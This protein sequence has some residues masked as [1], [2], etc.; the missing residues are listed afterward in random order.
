MR[1]VKGLTKESLKLLDRINKHSKYSQVRKRAHCIQLSYQKYKISQLCRIFKVSRNTIY[2][3]LNS[4]ESSRFV[5]LYN[6]PGRGRKKI[7]NINQ[8]QIIKSWVKETPLC[9]EKVQDKIENEWET[10]VSKKTIKRIIK[11]AHW[12]W[13]RVKK[14]VGGSPVT[15]VYKRKIQELE[16]LKEQELI[17]EIEIRYVDESGFCLIPYI[18]YAWQEKNHKLQIKSQQSKRLNVLGFLT[19]N[20]QLES[21]TFNCSINSDVVIACIDDFCRKITNKTVLILDNS[22]VHQNQFLWDKEDE[23]SKKGLE[24][25]FLPTYSPH[26]NIIEILWRFIKYKWLEINAYDSFHALTEAVENILKNFGTE[27]TIN[28]V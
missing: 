12:G 18:P 20:N 28:F 19:K 21:Y 25:F 26:L 24:I 7:F 4:W 9:L 1:Y 13:Y 22:S 2:N 16:Q 14:R 27:Y 3:W 17:G 10:R 23:W 8:E 15:T 5:G 11:S 6:Q